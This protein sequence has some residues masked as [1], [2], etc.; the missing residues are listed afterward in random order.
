VVFPNSFFSNKPNEVRLTVWL[1][2]G[3]TPSS[4]WTRSLVDPHSG[5][6]GA[7]PSEPWPRPRGVPGVPFT[8]GGVVGRR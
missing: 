6:V 7:K 3:D 8:P 2:V 4:V 5:G 1:S